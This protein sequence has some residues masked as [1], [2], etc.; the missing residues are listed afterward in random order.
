[1][2]KEVYFQFKSLSFIFHCKEKILSFW[3]KFAQNGYFRFKKKTKLI[4]I[5]FSIFIMVYPADIGHK[6]N[7]H[8]MFRRRPGRLLKVLCTFNLCPVSTGSTMLTYPVHVYVLCLPCFILN[9]QFW[10]FGPNLPK[11]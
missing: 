11:K 6:L 7:V 3:T 2:P 5:E 9:R 1:M 4:T 10:I 8:N